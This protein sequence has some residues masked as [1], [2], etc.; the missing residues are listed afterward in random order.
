[1]DSLSLM[2]L[3]HA[4]RGLGGSS[5]VDKLLLADATIDTLAVAVARPAAAAA[6]K[7]STWIRSSASAPCFA[8]SWSAI[9]ARPI[10]ICGRLCENQIHVVVRHPPRLAHVR[11]LHHQRRAD[12][13][14]L[15]RA[16]AD[17]VKSTSHCPGGAN[18]P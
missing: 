6:E 7:R 8:S 1:M 17:R 15:L 2:R 5:E 14:D 10:L 12:V 4:L 9:G 18:A 16:A 3:S 13:H 11:L